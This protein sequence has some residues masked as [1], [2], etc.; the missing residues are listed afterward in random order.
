MLFIYLSSF[1]YL[2]TAPLFPSLRCTTTM[3]AYQRTTWI[4]VRRVHERDTHPYAVHGTHSRHAQ[5]TR[6]RTSQLEHHEI[7]ARRGQETEHVSEGRWGKGRGDLSH[8]D[9]PVRRQ[10]QRR[11]ERA[12]ASHR[13]ESGSGVELACPCHVPWFSPRQRNGLIAFTAWKERP[14]RDHGVKGTP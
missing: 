8:V 2:V 6:A 9:P 12:S 13:R 3:K 1:L 14:N 7:P 4:T 11:T 10:S 5:N